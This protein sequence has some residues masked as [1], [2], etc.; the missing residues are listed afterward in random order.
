MGKI[1]IVLIVMLLVLMVSAGLYNKISNKDY[2][3]YLNDPVG[4]DL[5]KIGVHGKIISIDK[6]SLI[7]REG[8]Y[9]KEVTVKSVAGDW[10]VGMEINLRGVFHKEGYVEYKI[11]EEVKDTNI[12][13][14]LSVIGMFFFIFVLYKDWRKLKF[15]FGIKKERKHA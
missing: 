10:K 12:K 4:Q 2:L 15:D 14:I 7:I 6:G 5:C 11:A 8:T 13:T 1:K 9:G 3:V